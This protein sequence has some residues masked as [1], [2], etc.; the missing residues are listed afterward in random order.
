MDTLLSLTAFIII[1]G[2]MVFIHELGHFL[3]AKLCGVFVEEFALGMGPKIFSRKRGETLYRINLFPIGGYVKMLGEEESSD[4][5]R[6]FSMQPIWQRSI[7]VS[8]GVIMNIILAGI[9]YLAFLAV[10]SFNLIIPLYSDYRF[11][12][13]ETEPAIVVNYVAPDSPADLAGLE[14]GDL[15][16]TVDDIAIISSEEFR[17]Y[18]FAHGGEEVNLV[19]EEVYGDGKE[20]EDIVVTPRVDPAEGEGAVGVIL[21]E[22]VK[23][24]YTGADRVLSGFQHSINMI[25]YTIALFKDLV[26]SAIETRDIRYVSDNVSGPVG[27]YVATDMVLQSAGIVGLLDMAGLMSSSLAFMNLLPFPALDGGHLVL[28]FLEKVRGKKL[29]PKIE[30]WLTAGGFFLLM[31]FMLVISAKD[32]FQYGIVDKLMFWQ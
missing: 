27:V 16:K 23:I 18:V 6:S 20:D 1:L 3:A 11:L 30:Y 8:A 32:L 14:I 15:I 21:L 9:V 29:N 7:I 17:D 25:G 4:D 22:A 31:G 19:V 2:G 24:S 10:N 5:P 13:A 28:L 12:F 26:V